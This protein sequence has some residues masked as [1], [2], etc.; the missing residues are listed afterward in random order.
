MWIFGTY[1]GNTGSNSG[2]VYVFS[3]AKSTAVLSLTFSG[4]NPA[5]QVNA[6]KLNQFPYM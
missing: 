2:S 6:I 1:F 5:Y 4:L 3:Q